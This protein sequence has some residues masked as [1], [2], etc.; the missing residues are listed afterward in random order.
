[1]RVRLRMIIFSP[2]STSRVIVTKFVTA[3]DLL[4]GHLY[5]MPSLALKFPLARIDLPGGI[6]QVEMGCISPPE[7]SNSLS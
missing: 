2:R 1:M 6:L 4:P 5:V 7:I 3:T